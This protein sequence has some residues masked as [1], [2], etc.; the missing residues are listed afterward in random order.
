ML[1]LSS[2]K[3]SWRSGSFARRSDRRIVYA[4]LTTTG[5]QL[6]SHAARVFGTS[7]TNGLQ[8]FSFD[9]RRELISVVTALGSS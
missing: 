5:P 8:A 1:I 9:R 7:L 6:I 4:R 3:R 2:V